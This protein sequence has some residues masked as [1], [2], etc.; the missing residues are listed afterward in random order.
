[1]KPAARPDKVYLHKAKILSL[2]EFTVSEND[3]LVGNIIML[4]SLSWGFALSALLFSAFEPKNL[5]CLFS[6]SLYHPMEQNQMFSY[7]FIV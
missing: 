4:R 7:V 3:R 6:L 1:M 5:K 2:E